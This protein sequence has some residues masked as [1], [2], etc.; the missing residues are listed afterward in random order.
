MARANVKDWLTE[1]GLLLLEGWARDGLTDVQIAENIGCSRSTLAK[2]K[3]EQSD[4]SDTL[5]KGKE[6]VDRQVENALFKRAVGFHYVEEVATPAGDVVQLT[7]YERPDVTAGIYWLR[8]RK[9]GIWNNKDGIEIE[10][11][12]LEI[13]K[14]KKELEGS[15]SNEDKLEGFLELLGDVIDE[16]T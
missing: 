15:E 8:N 7:K 5:K 10:K 14:L 2:W 3:K 16:E 1:E 11:S 12:K 9:R 6:V 13:E 4:I